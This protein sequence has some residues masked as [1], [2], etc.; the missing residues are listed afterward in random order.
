[1]ALTLNCPHCHA[2]TSVTTSDNGQA[3]GWCE[4]CQQ[5]IPVTA[6]TPI[7][8]DRPMMARVVRSA[9]SKPKPLQPRRTT[10]PR[11][12]P[13]PPSSRWDDQ[14][15]EFAAQSLNKPLI[16]TLIGGSLL[17]VLIGIGIGAYFLFTTV[18]NPQPIAVNG[19]VSEPREWA[20]ADPIK[21]ETATPI[22][23]MKV[24][25]EGGEHSEQAAPNAPAL[26]S[27]GQGLVKNAILDVPLHG[28]S[29]HMPRDTKQRT[30][31]FQQ[32]KE[33]YEVTLFHAVKD[34]ITYQALY[35]DFFDPIKVDDDLIYNLKAVSFKQSDEYQPTLMSGHQGFAGPI[36]GYYKGRSAY[37]QV[38]SRL[39]AFCAYSVKSQDAEIAYFFD[40]INITYSSTT[41][42]RKPRNIFLR[43]IKQI[44]RHD[45]A[46]LSIKQN[47]LYTCTSSPQ[48]FK[49]F[50][51]EKDPHAGDPNRSGT[52][53]P[54]Y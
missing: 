45:M 54:P 37:I 2:E 25:E 19:P 47:R 15:D 34:G 29:A 17:L 42:P 20:R 27:P 12:K 51:D 7:L 43:D 3:I 13:R 9:Q 28:L 23:K 49:N 14:D 33:T 4:H 16:L 44:A 1:M 53:S 38:G 46:A 32:G 8:T 41:K 11:P 31:N 6:A 24:T 35:L 21:P 10:S 18:I 5:S 22:T 48:G 52:I 26:Q 39:F 50:Y 36:T 40:N 30:Q